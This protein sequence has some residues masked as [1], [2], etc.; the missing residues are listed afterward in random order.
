MNLAAAPGWCP[1]QPANLN[2]S[3]QAKINLYM[4]N[5]LLSWNNLNE[6]RILHK[7]SVKFIFEK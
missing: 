5:S 7:L 3:C 1:H 6:F 2:A 4:Y